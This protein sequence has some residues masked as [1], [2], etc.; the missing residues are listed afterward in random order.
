MVYELSNIY[1]N[2]FHEIHPFLLIW[3]NKYVNYVHKDFKFLMKKCLESEKIRFIFIKLTLIPSANGTHANILVYDKLKNVLE[4]FEPYGIIPYVDS[5]NLDIFI[6]KIGIECINKNI[7]YIKP[8][9]MF[10]SLG[11][12]VIS[13]DSNYN[14]RKLGDPNGYC[15]AWT[16]WFL[17]LRINN[18][19][20]TA[21]EIMKNNI[22]SIIKSNA[23]NADKLFIN[24]IRNYAANLD[25]EKN[26]FMINANI[27]INSIYDLNLGNDNLQKLMKKLKNDFMN[28]IEERI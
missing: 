23:V 11:P 6:H 2:Y 19:D 24:F 8:S 16:L 1:N 7:T 12:Q 22:G 5:D 18:P 26:K 27:N 25:K 15:L 9:D 10:D 17:E 28:I 20:I 3:K 14:I 21:K 13:D 4:R